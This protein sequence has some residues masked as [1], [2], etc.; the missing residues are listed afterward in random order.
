MMQINS[1]MRNI[2]APWQII[3]EEHPCYYFLQIETQNLRQ[4]N[5]YKV[6]QKSKSV[7]SNSNQRRISSFVEWRQVLNPFKRVFQHQL[8]GG[9]VPFFEN[10]F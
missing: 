5:S 8:D 10:E 4:L 3:H 6:D 1:P 2:S 7:K 9:T